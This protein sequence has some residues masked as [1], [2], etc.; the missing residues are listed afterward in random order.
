MSA[1]SNQ[2]PG[3][4]FI[5]FC[6]PLQSADA[7]CKYAVFLRR[8]AGISDEP[9][10]NLGIIFEHYGMP[11]PLYAPLPGQQ[12]VLLDD[13]TGQIL[14]NDGD[15]ETRQRFSQAH[16]LMERLFA[17]H[18]EALAVGRSGA[19]FREGHKESL[20][21]QGAAHLLLPLSSFL[22][23]LGRLGVSLKTASTLANEY[24]TSFLATLYQ[25]VRYGAGVHALVVWEYAL[26]PA[27][28][29]KLP[30]PEQMALL[31]VDLVPS[32]AKEL[33]VWW[34]AHTE[35][36]PNVYVPRHKSAPP[37][38][39]IYKAYDSC[40]PQVGREFIDLKGVRGTCLVE[41]KRVSIGDRSVV[42]SLLHLPGD[43]ACGSS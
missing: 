14:L 27:Q 18:E 33:R 30:P 28:V 32:P 39:L 42:V 26:K 37:E 8:E 16:E 2:H 29:K 12:A 31:P 41:A 36:V 23:R 21:E 7:L 10:I 22:P 11:P 38:S 1:R 5:E 4:R 24:E 40:V 20:C 25:M 34:S 6:G 17:A 43:R 35:A 13:E 19:R 9:P 15:P 3:R